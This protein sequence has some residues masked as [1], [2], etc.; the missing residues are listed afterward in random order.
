MNI[1]D[2]RLKGTL[3]DLLQRDSFCVTEIEIFRAVLRWWHHNS[4]DDC[5]VKEDTTNELNSVLKSVRLPLI[6]LSELLN[7]VLPFNFTSRGVL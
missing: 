7:E 3:C 5:V 4:Y 1:P 2:F 6:P